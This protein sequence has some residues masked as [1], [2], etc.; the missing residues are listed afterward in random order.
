[1]RWIYRLFDKKSEGKTRATQIG[2]VSRG[3]GCAGF[4][5]PAIFGSVKMSFD[6]IKQ[7]VKKEM[8]EGGFCPKK[9]KNHMKQEQD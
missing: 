1:M 6:W 3:A 5:S 9:E 2:V 7:V 8:S 4:N